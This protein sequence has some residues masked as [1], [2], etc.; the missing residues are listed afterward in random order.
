MSGETKEK[1]HL[2]RRCNLCLKRKSMTEDHIF[3]QGITPPGQRIIKNI[4]TKIDPHHKN[5]RNT[6][7]AQNGLKVRTLCA[8]CNNKL[9][10][11]RLDPELIEF[12]KQAD[13]FL[14]NRNLLPNQS[15]RIDS[16]QL[17]KVSR[18]VIGHILAADE[19]PQA[20]GKVSRIMRR[21]FF[22]ENTTLPNSINLFLWAYPFKEQTILRDIFLV[23]F[24][25]TESMM[26][27]TAYKTY[28]ISFAI[29]QNDNNYHIPIKGLLDIAPHLTGRIDQTF[30]LRIPLNPA[31]PSIWPE[32]PTS[33]GA[34]FMGEGRRVLSTPYKNQKIFPY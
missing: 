21:Y 24:S 17:N 26:W 12:C 25:R 22:K 30:S 4:L 23:D 15:I 29:C 31:V 18:A 8:L 13:L 34:V 16:I 3:P 5:R 27:T 9:L 11:T 32:A 33:N 2:E 28:P 19:K 10:G 14:R 6:K 7:L 20:R 1:H